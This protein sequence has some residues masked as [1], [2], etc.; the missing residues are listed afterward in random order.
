MFAR[1][2]LKQVGEEGE[3]LRFDIS[4]DAEHRPLAIMSYFG[5]WGPMSQ[6]ADACGVLLDPQGVIDI[7]DFH[8]V[9]IRY[10]KTNIFDRKIDLGQYVTVWWKFTGSG[11]ERIYIVEAV[12][13]LAALSSADV[14]AFAT[15]FLVDA[16]AKL[17]RFRARV[18]KSFDIPG[19]DNR[20]YRPPVGVEGDIAVFQDVYVFSPDDAV[21]K[22]GQ[23]IT[24]VVQPDEVEIL[25]PSGK[26]LLQRA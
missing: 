5:F 1:V 4:L 10:H 25:N 22:S 6:G 8:D 15:A 11:E 9:T 7:G 18:V 20:I 3:R 12:T 19:Y 21:A 16:V 23:M 2:C 24:V 14:P 26:F 17:P 13:D